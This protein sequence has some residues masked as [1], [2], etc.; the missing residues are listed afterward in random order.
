MTLGTADYFWELLQASRSSFVLL[1]FSNWP[2]AVLPG[3]TATAVDTWGLGRTSGYL[4]PQKHLEK[5][6]P[7]SPSFEPGSKGYQDP[8]GT[9]WCLV[10][11]TTLQLRDKSTSQPAYP[12]TAL[13]VPPSRER[14]QLHRTSIWPALQAEAQ[15]RGWES[16]AS[17][18]VLRCCD[19]GPMTQVVR[20]HD[21][22]KEPSEERLCQG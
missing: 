7:H 6:H 14:R 12:R 4:P 5:P 9:A 16:D 19:M 20:L 18:Q 10:R 21:S 13:L 8:A 1:I 3:T 22:L 11:L 17:R 15:K 2:L